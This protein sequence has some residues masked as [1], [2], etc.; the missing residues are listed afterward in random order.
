[1][2]EDNSASVLVIASD[3]ELP[4]GDRI[5]GTG[6]WVPPESREA[7]DW[8]TLTRLLGWPVEIVRPA[9]P[10]FGEALAADRR[11]AVVACDPDALCAEAIALLAE[12]LA[13]E[14]LLV[15]SRAGDRDGPLARVAGANRGAGP[16]AG[17]S[18]C[19][20]KPGAERR[21]ACRNAVSAAALEAAADVETWATLDGAPVLAARRV[22][23]GTVVT[24]GFHPSQARDEDGAATAL[25]RH[26]LIAGP[27]LPAAWLDLERTL[28]LRMDDPGS[29]QSVYC[30]TWSYPKL[31][32]AAWEELGAVLRDHDARLSVGYVA[33]WVDDGDAARGLLRVAG[34]EAERVTA[35]VHPSP[36]IQYL[37]RAGHLPGTLHDYEAEFSGLQ[38]LRQAGRAE[39][40]LHGY[41]HLHP[42]R[43]AWARAA[44]RYETSSWFREL[45]AA[46]ATRPPD[47]HPLARGIAAFADYFH[48]DPA[49]LICPGDQW[50]NAALER[51]LD[52][53]LQMVSSY[54][55]A[56]RDSGRFCWSTHVCAP[57][58]DRPGP[59]W[60]DAGL[61][62]V[63]YFHDR[64]PAVDGVAWIARWLERWR[65][66]G[67][68]RFLDLRELAAAVGRR[69]SLDESAGVLRLTVTNEA[70]PGLPRPLR[71]Q[72]WLPQQPLPTQLCVDVG[73]TTLM[74]PVEPL[75]EH[76][77]R[78][79]LPAG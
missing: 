24:L 60:F 53:G 33:G 23:R 47:E 71:I 31:G 28:V 49:A 34:R 79:S 25:L 32:E 20:T 70:A 74:L 72:L 40:E 18:L 62:V 61:P 57:Y 22:G 42:D 37:D 26:L 56:L 44:D 55:L 65:E 39:V 48:T 27:G 13:R 52:L 59:S 45:G 5:W 19:W 14:P 76:T 78:V 8:L 10:R 3:A 66:A 6:G 69:L 1:M 36:R 54:Y 63:G 38:S 35:R 15:V 67:A 11:C 77:G 21:W 29:C 50:T 46:A 12:R 58:L 73:D 9:E 68:E 16:L 4:A 2:A 17:R 75:D 43:L 30:R 51:A 64:E 7:L 41:T